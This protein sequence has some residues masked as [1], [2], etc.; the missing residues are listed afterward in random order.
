MNIMFNERGPILIDFGSCQ[1]F[2]CKLITA[3]TPGW[4][5]DDFTLSAPQ[6]DET[7]LNKIRTW[8]EKKMNSI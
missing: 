6:H 2:G 5:D 3:G 4:F 7:A 1:P 8:L